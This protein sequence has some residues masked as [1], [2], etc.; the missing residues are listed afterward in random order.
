LRW[1]FSVFFWKSAH[2]QCPMLPDES[3]LRL[4]L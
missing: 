3:P 2:R 4:W 1:P